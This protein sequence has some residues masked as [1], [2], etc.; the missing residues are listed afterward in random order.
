MPKVLAALE[1]NSSKQKTSHKIV[2]CFWVL[3]Q[4]LASTTTPETKTNATNT[5]DSFQYCWPW[6]CWRATPNQKNPCKIIVCFS[7]ISWHLA[8]TTT[9]ETKTNT[10]NSVDSF[11]YCWPWQCWRVTLPNQNKSSWD[12]CLFLGPWPALSLDDNSWNKNKC[13][14]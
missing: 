2:I 9:P 13:K 8:F 5:V 6:Q 12:L 1:S 7:L 11:W 10:T 14:Q 4:H 3:G